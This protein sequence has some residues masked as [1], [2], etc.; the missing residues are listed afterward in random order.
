MTN[1]SSPTAHAILPV[2]PDDPDEFE[3]SPDHPPGID[4]Y[5]DHLPDPVSAAHRV[6]D[7]IE[8]YGDGGVHPHVTPE[9]EGKMPPVFTRDLYSLTK[10]VLE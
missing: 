8:A 2:Q 1:P 5:T 10:A 7:F 9:F 4:E 6:N 3:Q